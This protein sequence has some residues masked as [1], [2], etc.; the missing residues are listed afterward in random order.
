MLLLNKGYTKKGRVVD[1]LLVITSVVMFAYF[2]TSSNEILF[3]LYYPYLV[4]GTWL[5]TA[6]I[7]VILLIHNSIST[8]VMIITSVLFIYMIIVTLISSGDDTNFSIATLVPVICVLALFNIKFKYIVAYN[9][10]KTFLEILIISVIVWNILLILRID[11]INEF[12]VNNYSQFF[13]HATSSSISLYKPIMSFGVH[14]FASFFY[15]IIFTLIYFTIKTHTVKIRRFYFYLL[16][17]LLFNI[18]LTSSSSLVFSI[19]M[20]IMIYNLSEKTITKISI[21]IVV[22]FLIVFLSNTELFPKYMQMIYSKTNGIIPRYQD[23]SIFDGNFHMLSKFFLGIGFNIAQNYDV[24]FTDSGYIVY[25]TMGNIFFM[26]GIYYLF[27]NFLN[28]NLKRNYKFYF[29]FFVLFFEIAIPILIYRK[30][31]FILIFI[32]FYLQSLDEVTS[33]NKA[34]KTNYIA[35]I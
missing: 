5:F 26:I 16:T 14:T 21:G 17:L 27:Y 10:M 8:R 28:T 18:L 9:V 23:A 31:F 3:E 12:T 13:E 2:P 22:I 25:F 1:V 33:I 15:L 34:R 7:I 19:I 6:I 30:F 29:L 24:R 4:I 11:M 35:N 32:I 20:L